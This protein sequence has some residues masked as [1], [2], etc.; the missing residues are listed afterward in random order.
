M[1]S[2][3]IIIVGGGIM[4]GSIAY[5]LARQG[6]EVTI[7]EKESIGCE[8]SGVATG[9]ISVMS[10]D[11]P[12]P[13]LELAKASFNL[14]KTLAPELQEKSGVN[15]Y[16]GNI[17]WLDL[18]FTE[19]EEESN[20]RD[21]DWKKSLVPQVT[22]V[23]GDYLNKID[24]R[25]SDKA[26]SGLYFEQLNQVDAYRLTLSY[27]GASE[28]LGVNVKYGEVIGLQKDSKSVT[29][30]ITTEGVIP[31]STVILAMGAWTQSAEAWI[32]FPIPIRPYKGQ[33]IQLSAPG[34][35]LGC[36]I[37]GGLSYVTPKLDGSI[38]AGSHDGFRGYDKSISEEGT[39]EVLKGA[40]KVCP[41][42]EEAHIESVVTGLRPATPDEMP[43]LGQVP[44]LEGAFVASGHK[45]KG[46]T[47]AAITGELIADTVLGKKPRI[48][49]DPFS[50]SRFN[51]Q[52][53]SKAALP[54]P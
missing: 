32:D 14:Y 21:L 48:S 28:K 45:R 17:S 33:M 39:Q 40:L 1:Q 19:E 26:R 30:V 29:G 34:P 38:L 50:L 3:D 53:T 49:L 43:I 37:H 24:P 47:L 4:G 20:R 7:L 23:D 46:I 25:I 16:Y 36:N 44:T 54:H 52:N 27:I 13:Y 9:M 8:A 31:C 51:K 6:A 10:I 41:A 5:H 22:W 2:P 35:P 42:M 12:G 18:A 15:C 11:S